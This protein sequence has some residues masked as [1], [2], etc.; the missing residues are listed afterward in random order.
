M[1]PLRQREQPVL[2]EGREWTRQRLEEPLQ[3]DSIG[4]EMVCPQ[5][6]EE[7]AEVRWRD[8]QLETVVGTVRLKVGH[9]YS[10]ELQRWICP[11]REL[12]GFSRTGE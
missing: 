5:S 10:A 4:R 1:N 11:A 2:A 3:L 7:L 8:L 12:W 9:G 6:G